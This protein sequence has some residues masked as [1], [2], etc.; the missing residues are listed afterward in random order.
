M[1]AAIEELVTGSGLEVAKV[2]RSLSVSRSG[3]HAW[4]RE[5]EGPRTRRDRELRPLIREIFRQHR[6]RCGALRIARELHAQQQPYSVARVS[7]LLQ[8]QGLRAIQPHSF[9][10]RTTQSHHR[11]G[12]SPNLLAGRAAAVEPD[13]VWVG[14]ITYIRLGDQSFGYLS[15]LLN[16]YSRRIAGWKFSESMQENLV[17]AALREAIV[18]RQPGSGLIHHTDR[19][20]QYAGKRYRAV[21]R[22]AGMQQS[23]SGAGNCYDNAF[24]ESCF[25]TLKTELELTG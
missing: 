2:Y 16:L 14:D 21:L 3:F 25:G 19:G 22:R 18:S 20:G 23:M 4:R 8:E 13:E 6:R 11:L 9:Q 17:L 10:P 24:M 12:Y 7:R 1:Y 15:L 5:V